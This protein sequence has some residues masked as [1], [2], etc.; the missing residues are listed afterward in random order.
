MAKQSGMLFNDEAV[1]LK[2]LVL[3]FPVAAVVVNIGSGLGYSTAAMLEV[4]NDLRIY[5]IDI[6]G[7]A[8]EAERLE[9]LGLPSV[10]SITG[11]SQDIGRTWDP[12]SVRMVYVDGGHADYEAREDIELWLPTIQHGGILAVHDH[13]PPVPRSQTPRQLRH[14]AWVTQAC[15]D[16]L[17]HLDVVLHVNRLKAFRVDWSWCLK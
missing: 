12:R 5:S 1:A 17:S 9:K 8:S 7:G 15:D 6:L 11:R 13:S 14:E 4:R 16:L 10:K 3:P 2:T